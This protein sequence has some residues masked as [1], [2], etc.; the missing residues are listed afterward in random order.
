MY[1]PSDKEIQECLS[2]GDLTEE[3]LAYLEDAMKTADSG[4][5]VIGYVFR[6]IAEIRHKRENYVPL[7]HVWHSW[8]AK[9]PDKPDVCCGKEIYDDT[10]ATMNRNKTT[11]PDCYSFLYRAKPR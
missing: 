7:I 9:T 3:Q 6:M 8:D 5:W 1:H 4:G 2:L 11:C 10:Q